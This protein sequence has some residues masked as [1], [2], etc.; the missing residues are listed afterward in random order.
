MAKVEFIFNGTTTTIQCKEN[1]TMNEIIKRFCIKVEKNKEGMCFL[2]GGKIIEENK[3]FNEVANSDDKQRKK[4]SILVNDKNSVY[5]YNNLKKSKYILCPKCHESVRINI[6]DFKIKLFGCKNDHVTDNLSFPDLNNSMIIDESKIICD[7]CKKVNKDKTYNNTFFICNTCNKN[8]CPLCNSSHDKKH[9][10]SEYDQKYFK[11]NLHNESF[12]LYCNQCKKNICV[13]CEKAHNN[14]NIISLGK[15]IPDENKLLEDRNN[16]RVI[17]NKCKSNIQDIII[18]L[19]DVIINIES[20]YNIYNSIVS[21]YEI[22]KRNFQI[23]YS[24]FHFHCI[25]WL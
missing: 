9:I 21:G 24:S 20:Y 7:I 8:I 18:K 19:N 11:C 23:F 1:E 17:I 2:Y 16:L 22:Q 15:M 13:I 3:T 12:T 4:L 10:I 14:H 25:E 6:N 5:N